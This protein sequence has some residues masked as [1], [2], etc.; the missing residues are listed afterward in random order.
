M[1]S[2]EHSSS[3][4]GSFDLNELFTQCFSSLGFLK[5]RYDESNQKLIN[6]TISAL[7]LAQI[8]YNLTKI[9]LIVLGSTCSGK[10]TL[11]NGFLNSM[12]NSEEK[13]QEYLP[14]NAA[15]NT[16]AYT[17]ISAIPDQ[18]IFEKEEEKYE[19]FEKFKKDRLYVKVDE[20]PSIEFS[21]GK[22]LC[23]FLRDFEKTNKISFYDLKK[24]PKTI[25][26]L[27]KIHIYLPN[28]SNSIQIIDTPGIS[29]ASFMQ[30]LSKIVQESVCIFLY[31]KNLDNNQT[32]NANVMDF[33]NITKGF[34]GQ[35]NYQFWLVFTKED[36][37]AKNYDFDKSDE[38]EDI[39]KK[40][41]EKKQ[42]FLNFLEN[43]ERE[44]KE[45][46]IKINRIY[47]VSTRSAFKPKNPDCGLTREIL[48]KILANIA[49]FKE[50]N[51]DYFVKFIYIERISAN[52]HVLNENLHRNTQLTQEILDEI[53]LEAETIE[54]IFS[55]KVR[56]LLESDQFLR[57]SN[58]KQANLSKFQECE[59]LIEKAK[60]RV[61]KETFILKEKFERRI[62]ELVSQEIHNLILRDEIKTIF[63]ESYLIFE[64]F[65]LNL[66]DKNLLYFFLGLDSDLLNQQETNLAEIIKENIYNPMVDLTLDFKDLN[67]FD[68]TNNLFNPGYREVFFAYLTVKLL[69]FDNY[70]E[71]FPHTVSKENI[72]DFILKNLKENSEK[73]V[74]TSRMQFEMFINQCIVRK[75]ENAKEMNQEI[76]EI[77]KKIN[78]IRTGELRVSQKGSFVSY[79]NSIYEMVEKECG[80]TDKDLCE[81]F[82][83]YLKRFKIRKN[84]K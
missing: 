27:P 17:F 76:N 49:E 14:S 13:W 12:R 43:T 84:S 26:S 48:R 1:M 36:L 35:G 68:L 58:F 69:K 20:N 46:S 10:T 40:T 44:I 75:L 7:K 16:C 11:I 30:E 2:I 62:L 72:M 32:N 19:K 23:D 37:F 61:K 24:Q 66:I 38:D 47:V 41:R 6:S 53:K 63:F 25:V 29:T 52:L 42:N 9:S 57:V 79:V 71:F 80:F 78:R 22:D 55:N 67:F 56:N 50:K 54:D 18:I 64:K 59:F 73:I 82:K 8:H 4:M 51:G 21:S 28:L 60:K 45:N 65:L 31:V 15:E 74:E 39:L 5:T 33:F 3:L 77:I 81:F 34:Y 83:E 70:V